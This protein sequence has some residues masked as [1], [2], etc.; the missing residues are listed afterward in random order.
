MYLLSTPQSADI[1]EHDKRLLF[2]DLHRLVVDF[3][4]VLTDE[5]VMASIIRHMEMLNDDVS[6]V[7]CVN[8][9]KVN[10]TDFKYC[11]LSF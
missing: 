4:E 1:K 10:Q 9:S 11:L 6:E 8:F 5:S 2:E 3:H 7:F